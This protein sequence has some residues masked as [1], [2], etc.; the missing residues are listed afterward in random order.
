LSLLSL[1]ASGVH[2]V[3][4]YRSAVDDDFFSLEEMND[5]I[6]A[7]ERE[8]MEEEDDDVKKKSKKRKQSKSDVDDDDDDDDDDDGDE[9]AVDDEEIDYFQGTFFC[10][11]TYFLLPIFNR[12]PFGRR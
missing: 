5:F 6:E 12:H 2:L 8:A 9:E 3:R 11:V 4:L 1:S 10:F 7:T